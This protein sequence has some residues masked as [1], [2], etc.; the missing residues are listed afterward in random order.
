MCINTSSNEECFVLDQNADFRFQCGY[1]KPTGA[2]VIEDKA[3]ILKTSLRV[4]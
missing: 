2:V 4:L 3:E 1:L